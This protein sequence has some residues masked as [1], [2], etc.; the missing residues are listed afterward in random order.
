MSGHRRFDGLAKLISTCI[1]FKRFA[2]NLS[3]ILQ[4]YSSF[5]F[6]LFYMSCW[7]ILTTVWLQ[8]EMW[9][10]FMVT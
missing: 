9:P 6:P 7:L 1:L 4:K 3:V 5:L 2:D 10:L 8:K